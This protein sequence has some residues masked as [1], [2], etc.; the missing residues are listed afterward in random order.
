LRISACSSNVG[1]TGGG[2]GYPFGNIV[3]L[4]NLTTFKINPGDNVEY[5]MCGR[6]LS[7]NRIMEV[8]IIPKRVMINVAASRSEVRN[9]SEKRA[10]G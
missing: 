9:T 4:L 2:P 3:L 6:S 10:R 8:E 1:S 7:R 5:N